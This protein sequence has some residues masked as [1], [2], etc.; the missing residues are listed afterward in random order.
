MIVLNLVSFFTGVGLASR[1]EADTDLLMVGLTKSVMKLSFL[2]KKVLASLLFGLGDIRV[3]VVVFRFLAGEGVG[4][5]GLDLVEVEE[6]FTTDLEVLV[7]VLKDA[8]FEG[9]LGVS[10]LTDVL[11]TIS[12]DLSKNSLIGVTLR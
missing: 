10:V 9:V 8:D 6:P 1:S 5:T 7:G 4:I 2:G 12:T 11:P 3:G